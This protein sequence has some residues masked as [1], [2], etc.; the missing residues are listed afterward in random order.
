V[1]L[2]PLKVLNVEVAL[3]VELVRVWLPRR[4]GGDASGGGVGNGPF[5]GGEGGILVA[6]C[7]RPGP[8][9]VEVEGERGDGGGEDSERAR[10]G[11]VVMNAPGMVG[12]GGISSNTVGGEAIGAGPVILLKLSCVGDVGGIGLP[13][14]DTRSVGGRVRGKA[15][16]K[17]LGASYSSSNP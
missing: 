4:P 16:E 12:L 14:S 3:A 5:P 15:E 17:V 9:D 10:V 11:G 8:D 1:P 2:I 7:R 6:I 13:G